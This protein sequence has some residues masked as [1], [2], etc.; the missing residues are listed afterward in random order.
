MLITTSVAGSSMSRAGAA[1]GV[2]MTSKCPQKRL[3]IENVTSHLQR[4]D[5]LRFASRIFC[6]SA[7]SMYSPKSSSGSSKSGAM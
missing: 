1:G 2:A 6:S 5:L 7:V 4:I 3:S